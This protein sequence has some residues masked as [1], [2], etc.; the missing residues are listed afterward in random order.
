M[1]ASLDAVVQAVLTD[2]NANPKSLL[3]KAVQQFQATVLDKTSH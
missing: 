1:Y 3:D 2:R